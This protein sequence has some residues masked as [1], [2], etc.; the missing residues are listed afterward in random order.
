M[1]AKQSRLCLLDVGNELEHGMQYLCMNQAARA[2]QQAFV[3]GIL[4]ERMFER[5]HGVRRIAATGRKPRGHE[6]IESL[7]QDQNGNRCDCVKQLVA[8][9]T[10]DGSTDLRS[11]FSSR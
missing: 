5:V 4:D 11:F 10:T 3:S 6:L 2:A 7:L 8:E 9:L 1:M